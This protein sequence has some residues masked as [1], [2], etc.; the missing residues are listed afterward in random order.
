MSSC[1][2]MFPLLAMIFTPFS[3]FVLYN[4]NSDTLF[5]DQ[6]IVDAQRTTGLSLEEI[7]VGGSRGL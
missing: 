5:V 7:E 3:I 1:E 4:R 2:M 6:R